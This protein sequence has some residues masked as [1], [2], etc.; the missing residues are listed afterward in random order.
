MFNKYLIYNKHKINLNFIYSLRNC[1]L[2]LICKIFKRKRIFFAKR[3]K[4]F[5]DEKIN[6]IIKKYIIIKI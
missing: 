6:N 4:N 2:I 5:K 3:H 1:L